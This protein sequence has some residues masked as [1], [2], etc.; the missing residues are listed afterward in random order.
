[1]PA[2][3][4][5][6]HEAFPTG[7]AGQS[8]R[9]GKEAFTGANNQTHLYFRYHLEP[10]HAAV[11]GYKTKCPARRTAIQEAADWFSVNSLGSNQFDQSARSPEEH[12]KETGFL[13]GP[14]G[15][16]LQRRWANRCWTEPRLPMLPG[17][18]RSHKG[19]AI[20]TKS[21]LAEVPS[22]AKRLL[23]ALVFFNKGRCTQFSRH[24]PHMHGRL[25]Q[26]WW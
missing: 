12:M 11:V 22:R 13:E 15:P 24:D 26:D 16:R 8:R 5:L 3:F 2:C 17:P 10:W 1:M 9:G 4:P 7:V 19:Q 18:P 25:P 21:F 6:S 23:C 14:L 20:T